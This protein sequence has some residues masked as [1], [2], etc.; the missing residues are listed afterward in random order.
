MVIFHSYVSLPEGIFL[1]P[2][3]GGQNGIVLPTAFGNQRWQRRK[4]YAKNPHRT[5]RLPGA[6]VFSHETALLSTDPHEVCE[7]LML[8]I[9]VKRAMKQILCRTHGEGPHLVYRSSL[10]GG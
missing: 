9:V 3:M 5:V 7:G 1:P 8:Q 4:W 10:Q 2:V 6:C